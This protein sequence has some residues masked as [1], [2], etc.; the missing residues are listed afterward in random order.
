MDE[1]L[2]GIEKIRDTLYPEYK[3]PDLKCDLDFCRWLHREFD[4]LANE[5]RI[6]GRVLT[7]SEYEANRLVHSASA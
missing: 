7:L 1:D 6:Y 4:S 3:T 2:L 5:Y